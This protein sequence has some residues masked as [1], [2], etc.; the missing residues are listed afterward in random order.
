MQLT[1]QYLRVKAKGI[2]QFLLQTTR[3]AAR[4]RYEITKKASGSPAR[5]HHLFVLEVS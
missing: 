2:S 3:P 4:R 1:A 5:M